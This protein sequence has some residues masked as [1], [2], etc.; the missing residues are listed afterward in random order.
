MYTES[1]EGATEYRRARKIAPELHIK[2]KGENNVKSGITFMGATR[3]GI[4]AATIKTGSQNLQAKPL[5]IRIIV[6]I[7]MSIFTF[8]VE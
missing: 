4:R 6:L 5:F 7:F 1:G 8:A 3:C 2:E